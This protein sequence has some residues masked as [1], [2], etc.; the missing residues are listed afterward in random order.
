[1][2]L[3]VSTGA[4]VKIKDSVADLN[5]IPKTVGVIIVLIVDTPLVLF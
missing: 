5:L 4:I 1:M 3:A 2:L